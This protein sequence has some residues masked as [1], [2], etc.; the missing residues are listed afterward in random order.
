ML[1]STGFFVFT[2]YGSFDQRVSATLDSLEKMMMMTKE[3]KKKEEE[4]EE[5][6]KKKKKKK[7]KAKP[8]TDLVSPVRH[9]FCLNLRDVPF[10]RSN[11]CRRR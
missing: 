4:E 11:M 1:Y 5:E 8:V 7:R 2:S 10:M 3:K 6:E 9:L